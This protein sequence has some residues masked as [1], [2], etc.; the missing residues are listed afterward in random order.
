MA[1]PQNVLDALNQAD[2][3]MQSAASADAA[4]ATAVTALTTAQAASGAISGKRCSG[5]SSRD[6]LAESGTCS[7]AA[8][9]STSVSL[10]DWLW[11]MSP[12]V[13]LAIFLW[14]RGLSRDID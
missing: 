5:D 4:T 6:E 2:V 10:R 8:S 14:L 7:R 13:G 1:I 9:G 3:D 12:I 11:I